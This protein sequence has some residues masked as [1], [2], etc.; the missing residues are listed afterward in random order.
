MINN[1]GTDKEWQWLLG[2]LKTIYNHLQPFTM[3]LTMVNNDA[4]D[5]ECPFTTIYNGLQ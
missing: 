3:G 4:T 5:K 1:D 2:V